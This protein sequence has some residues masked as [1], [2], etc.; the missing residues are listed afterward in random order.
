MNPTALLGT[1]LITLNLAACGTQ[2]PPPEASTQAEMANGPRADAPQTNGPQADA[3]RADAPVADD[4]LAAD[5]LFLREEE[6]LARDVYRTLFEKW[7]LMPHQNIASSEQTHTDRVRSTLAVFNLADPVADDSVGVFVNVQLAALYTDLVNKGLSSEIG[8]LE[9]GATIEDLDIRDLNQMINRTQ[10]PS[11]LAMY[12][13]LQCGSRNH[14]RAFT[15][16]LSMRGVTY[17]PQFLD[18]AEYD[19]I[20]AGSHERCG[21]R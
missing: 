21:R 8:S 5:L 10:D 13:A 6:K 16:Q 18:R 2:G 4:P 15:S 12:D 19:A 9:V 17:Q 14:L 7:R 20:L 3:P 11:V 1:V